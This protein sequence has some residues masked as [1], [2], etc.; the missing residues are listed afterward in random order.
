M[1]RLL[2]AVLIVLTLSL[3]TGCVKKQVEKEIVLHLEPKAG[4]PRNSEG[5]FV[6]LKGGRILFIYSHF[7]ESSGD[8]T[9]AYLASRY[10][11]DGGKTWSK[12]DETVVPNEGGINV[13]SVSLLRLPGDK[14]ALLYLR[15]NSEN[16]CIPYMRI[17]TDEAKSWS[18]P[19]RC[20]ADSG[21][22]VVNNDR[23]VQLK[24]GRL[25]FPASL[26]IQKK[27]KEKGAGIIRCYYSD[28]EGKFW[29]KS[30]DA[31]NPDTASTQEPGIVELKDGRIM[32]FCRTRSGVQYISY[33]SDQGESWSDLKPGNIVSPL[34]PA[35]IE[36]IPQT[37]DLL[38]VWN[39]TYQPMSDDGGKRTPFNLAISKDEGKTWEK[40]KFI[41]NDPS[42]WY[43]Y[44]A[45]E[46]IGNHV[47]LGHC[48]GDR[49]R[50]SGLETT[51]I[52]RLNLPWV[53]S[54]VTAKP[55]IK[56]KDIGVVSLECPD[57]GAEIYYSLERKM[58]HILY[59]KPIKL[60][61]TTPLWAAAKAPGKTKSALIR[62]QVGTKIPQPAVKEKIDGGKGV[63]FEYYE[64]EVN[65]AEDIKKLKLIRKGTAEN[66]NIDN[67]ERDVNFAYIFEG[68]ITAPRTGEY[69]FYLGSNDGSVLYLDNYVL[70]DMNWPHG[71]YTDSIS[72][73][74]EK[75]KHK[76]GLKY[77]QMQRGLG[78]RV[79]WQGPGIKKE[80]IPA[81]VLSHAKKN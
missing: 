30:K 22:F 70:I 78:L 52:T 20:I 76:I 67:R 45:I 5:D 47:L 65:N 38:L 14:I 32:L 48:A 11:D 44:T 77:F 24:S 54:E 58:P 25:I 60:L 36:C 66:F 2:P 50:N 81:A 19:T 62:A 9:G 43:C 59:K 10:S 74:L 4:N 29:Q 16:D 51:Q 27:D 17:S 73:V 71:F 56:E 75:G 34:S 41:E 79:S 33:S 53:Y 68:Y 15:K 23:L 8:N 49:V 1:K 40:I 18:G 28:D 39:N 61:H 69:T 80:E 37:G 55:I 63:I 72:V 13:M 64:G 6:Q 31:A 3:I 7:T 42:G 26:H 57:E 46:F 12:K 21:Y 35:S